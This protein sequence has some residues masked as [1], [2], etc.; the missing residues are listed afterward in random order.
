MEGSLSRQELQ[1]ILDITHREYFRSKYLNPAIE[2]ELVGLTIPDKPRSGNQKYYLTEKGK[3]V[4]D[5]LN[6]L[7]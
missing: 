4:L 5:N 3:T 7:V 2:M 6:K 1:D